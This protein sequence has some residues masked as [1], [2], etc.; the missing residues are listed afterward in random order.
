MPDGIGTKVSVLGD[1]EY[2][3][4]LSD[5]G[6]SLRVLDS[7]MKA[8][9]SG[10]KGQEDG[11][12]A[13][14]SK[15]G[16]LRKI[17]DEQAAKVKLVAEQLEKAKAEYGENSKQADELQIALNRAQ[18][19]LN[20]TGN[21]LKD[22]N[23]KLE[24]AKKAESGL[25]AESKAMAGDVKEA[26]AA[27][28]QEGAEA[29]AGAEQNDRY[30][31]SLDDLGTSA[32]PALKAT[33]LGIA[34]GFAAVSAATLEGLKNLFSWSEQA[35][36]MADDVLTLSVQT[37]V[38]TQSLQKWSYA[39]QFTD[40]S[41]ET[42]TG[43]MAKLVKSMDSAAE[44]SKSL[45][46]QSLALK[47]AQTN[48]TGA[49]LAVENAQEKY[50]AAV[51][52]HGKGSTEAAA[53]SNAL[54]KAQN[55]LTL[56][57]QKLSAAMDP[58]SDEASAT[59][60][61]FAT[62]GVKIKDDVTGELRDNEDVFMDAIDALGK[63]GNETERDAL[64][65][66]IFGKSA[67]E[68][69]PLIEAGSG[70]LRELG[71]EA[72][73]L[74]TV[75]SDEALAAMG[76][77]DD[78][79]QR[80]Q[81][82]LTGM[83]NAVGLVAIPLFQPLIDRATGAM[84]EV[85][86]ALQDGLQPG[87]LDTLINDL[88]A[89]VEETLGDLGGTLNKALPYLTKALKTLVT[90]LA[91]QLP[92]FVE[93]MLPATMDLLDGV[94]EA[95]SE[96]ADDLGDLAADLV[97][98]LVDFLIDNA[99]DMADAAG[100]ILGGLVD[101]LLDG[102]NLAKLVS[103]AITMLGK[104]AAA[105]VSNA[106]LLA[107]KA[108]E[109]ISQL[110]NGLVEVDWP[111]V[112]AEIV[113]GIG[114]AIMGAFSGANKELAA[115]REEFEATNQAYTAFNTALTTADEGLAKS[116]ADAEAKKTLATELL[117]LYEQ[118]EQK[119]IKT[120][121]DLTTMADYASRIAELYPSLSQYI[122]PATGL[123]TANTDAIR[124][125]IEAQY[126]WDLVMGYQD[127]LTKVASAMAEAK[128]NLDEH[129]IAQQAIKDKWD[130]LKAQA[131]GLTGLYDKVFEPASGGGLPAF[132]QN[133]TDVY[134]ALVAT[135]EANP[136]DGF[137][138]VLADGTVVL[139]QG[140]S[141]IDA[142]NTAQNAMAEQVTNTND[143]FSEQNGKLLASYDGYTLLNGQYVDAEGRM[144][145]VNSEL[146][147]LITQYNAE[148]QAAAEGGAAI[149]QSGTDAK[150]G[151]DK[152]VEATEVI[153]ASGESMDTTAESAKTAGEE[154][155]DT[156]EKILATTEQLKEAKSA[157]TAAQDAIDSV[158]AQISTDAATS[159]QTMEDTGAAITLYAEGMME[160][161][162][163]AV[164]D[165]L[166]AIAEAGAGVAKGLVKAIAEYVNAD[167]GRAI[168]KDIANG[169][170]TGMRNKAAAISEAAD[171]LA[172]A[173][174]DALWGAVG[175]GGSAFTG[176]GAAVAS[177][178]AKGIR[179]NT[180]VITTAAQ[181]A[182]RAA[183]RA[184]IDELDIH[185]PSRVTAEAGRYF[186]LGFAQGI[187]GG[188]PDLMAGVRELSAMAAAELDGGAGTQGAYAYPSAE[189]PEIDYARL[190][191]EVAAAIR[192]EGLGNAVLV[193]D[194][195][196][197]E[198]SVSKAGYERGKQTVKGRMAAARLR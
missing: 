60:K 192:A 171:T 122:D 46:E 103:S 59:A 19:A 118:L 107:A 196:I 79:M 95:V 22:T 34:A 11:I 154:V 82:T 123:F 198:P 182:A 133:L 4:A 68:L 96:N 61:A 184:M 176:I 91:K 185:S 193:L 110:I 85:S 35:G 55:N 10:Y 151:A 150:E 109:I 47:M 186:D 27:V 65:M 148:A 190:G 18:T 177:G 183:Y 187:E 100:D 126:A 101:G 191:Q 143:A 153:T 74:G 121:V 116:Q 36:K 37:G 157:A 188:A 166:D 136:L 67:Q 145:A 112:A 102:N 56:A 131:E 165:G 28:R 45:E 63:V 106:I 41:V 170:D 69:N 86:T 197:I 142:Y 71:D 23:G 13:L 141:E 20:G 113:T 149:N 80:F 42:M 84:A 54:E 163:T 50:A 135:G 81:Q 167:A 5:I 120:D 179:G 57:Q 6:R 104:L 134:N 125:N 140:V 14:T 128:Q 119:D 7:E 75:F 97:L 32:G 129:V 108:P 130:E 155:A 21:E 49:A 161:I 87:E 3:K 175:S 138:Q 147:R 1:K 158:T 152:V 146:G 124:A 24:D 189:A 168:A 92:T 73:Q 111:A 12:E 93:T 89:G 38:S 76:G 52:K 62:L 30:G 43:S 39:S 78:S 66:T 83:E 117:A 156:A 169:L 144:V 58:A 15:S 174:L 178:V 98:Q 16:S 9:Q 139:Q 64:A 105:L 8:A 115:Y 72:E 172:A 180:S 162:G 160:A 94:L 44:G 132:K 195:K 159:L 2:K 25:S 51:K 70:K 29:D 173:A 90:S 33:I 31:R 181:T 164:T 53:A 17:Y 40:T 88:L 99:P 114:S 26:G 194:G 137:V 127:Y 48:E 77:F